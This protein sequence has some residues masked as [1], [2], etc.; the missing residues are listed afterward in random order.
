MAT[1]VT[2]TKVGRKEGTRIGGGPRFPGPNGKGPSGNGK[3]GEHDERGRRFSPATYRITMWVVLAAV[4]MM[5]AALSSAY[6]ILSSGGQSRPVAMP[7]MFFLSTG[8][9]LLSSLSFEKAKRSLKQGA[10]IKYLRWIWLTLLLGLA[11]LAA[12]LT[13]W[14]ELAAE[15]VYFASH[16]HS[17]FFYFF[18]GVHGVHLIGGILGLFYLILRLKRR[19]ELLVSERTITAAEVVALYWHAMDGL[20]LW[21]FLL[22][23]VW[24]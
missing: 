11:F 22:L 19:K 13:G 12:Q 1:R 24:K 2:D 7:R 3:G 8:V 18:T 5:F 17:S 4:V 20:W 10:Q 6:I 21:L 14:R 9:I 15:G 16:P 23:L